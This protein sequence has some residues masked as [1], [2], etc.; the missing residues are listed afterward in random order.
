MA[1]VAVPTSLNQNPSSPAST[2]MTLA[3]AARTP[4]NMTAGKRRNELTAAPS[5]TSFV[6]VNLGDVN[7]GR[8]RE[9][10][11][12]RNVLIRGIY[13]D[14]T[15]WS[16]VSAGKLEHVAQYVEAMPAALR[17]EER[18]QYWLARAE[19]RIEHEPCCTGA[20][21]WRRM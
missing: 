6:F 3:N 2:H 15:H 13:Q 5:Q 20:I 18:W 1:S 11:A 12:K 8:F 10:M 7:A 16:R 17:T 14:Y 4:A 9:E 19:A 21:S